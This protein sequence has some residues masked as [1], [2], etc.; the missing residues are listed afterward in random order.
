MEMNDRMK[1]NQKIRDKFISNRNG[2][3]FIIPLTITIVIGFSLLVIGSYITGEIGS[4][5][6]DTY[7]DNTATGTVDDTYTHGG[8]T[9]SYRNVSLP[10]TVDDLSGS[11]TNFYIQING[12]HYTYYNLSV[13]GAKVNISSMLVPGIGYN[14]T[15]ATLLSNGN[16]STSNTSLNFSW[17]CNNSGNTIVITVN[18]VYYQSSDYRSTN[19]NKTVTLIGDITDGFSDVIDVEV[20]VIII[21]VLS[22]ALIAIMAIGS[23]RQLF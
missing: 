9:S 22:M 18:G 5:L 3:T 16:V 21:T 2:F 12:S 8:T 10:T 20:V 1:A 19:E 14:V 6:E 15:L 11:R 23:R 4:A 7:E 17:D 13:N